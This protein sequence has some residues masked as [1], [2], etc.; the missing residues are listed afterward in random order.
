VLAIDDR[1][2]A[3]FYRRDNDGGEFRPVEILG[4]LIDVGCAPPTDFSLIRYIDDKFVGLDP[5]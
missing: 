2:Q 3:A 4:D 5:F 1:K